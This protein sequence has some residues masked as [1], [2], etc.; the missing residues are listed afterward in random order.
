M[1]SLAPKAGRLI[2]NTGSEST[3]LLFGGTLAI[4]Y[5]GSQYN[6]PVDI[7]LCETYPDAPPVCYVRPTPDMM[8]KPGHRHVDAEGKVYLPY[9]HDW[10]AQ[11]HNLVELCTVMASVF[12]SQ[13]PV[14]SRPSV[15]ASAATRPAARP[16]ATSASA[17]ASVSLGGTPLSP[18]PPTYESVATENDIAVR[19]L[20]AQLQ[21]RLQQFYSSARQQIDAE[22]AKQARLQQG[23]TAIRVAMND[24]RD[25]K[26]ALEKHQSTASAKCEALERWSCEQ[27]AAG[28]RV[29]PDDLIVANDVNSKQMVE[30]VSESAAI[31][32]ALYYLDRALS[33][34]AIDVETFLREVRK[35]AR[36]QFLCKAHIRK[37][38]TAKASAGSR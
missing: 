18:P 26:S 35:L 23:Q 3:L 14:F 34:G 24:L 1:R 36:R 6:I 28:A 32:D 11:T 4:N 16:A 25:Q 12:Q 2:S 37:V 9:L 29:E 33:Q 30:L 22:F 38:A 5:R 10:R 17:S 20:T 8:V 13:P 7:Y 15:G 21:R 19:D 31:E 27:E